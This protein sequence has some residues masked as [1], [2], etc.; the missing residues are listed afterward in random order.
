MATDM[1]NLIKEAEAMGWTAGITRNGHLRFTHPDRRTVF[2]SST[3]GDVRA[4]AN[5]RGKLRRASAER[6]S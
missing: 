4:I 1:Q 3:P 2:A 5:T 6:A